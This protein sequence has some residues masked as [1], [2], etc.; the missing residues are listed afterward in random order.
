[1]VLVYVVQKDYFGLAVGGR[2]FFIFFLFLHLAQFIS[3]AISV[4]FSNKY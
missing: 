1:M 4:L 3:S 2:I